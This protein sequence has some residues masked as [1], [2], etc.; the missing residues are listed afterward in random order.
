[1]PTHVILNNASLRLGTAATLAA[2]KELACYTNHIELTPDVSTTTLD[3]MCGSVDYP[4]AV[5]WT[6]IATIYQSWDTP[7]GPEAVLQPL[8]AAAPT[9]CWFVIAADRVAPISATNPGWSGSVVPQ[10][11]SPLNGDAGDASE[12]SIEWSLTAAPTKITVPPA[13]DLEEFEQQLAA[14]EEEA[15]AA[16]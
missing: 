3:T 11:Y 5:K 2:L 16:A 7:N 13:A 9:P 1:M 12:I 4:G 10:P 6:L 8:V 14:A 15:L